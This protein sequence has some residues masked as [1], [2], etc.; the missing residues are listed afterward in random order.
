MAVRAWVRGRVGAIFAPS[1]GS[2][3]VHKFRAEPLRQ[4]LSY[5]ACHDVG[6]TTGRK[7]DNDAR[8]ISLRPRAARRGRERGSTPCQMQ[9]SPAGKFHRV[10]GPP[11]RRTAKTEPLPGSLATVTTPPIL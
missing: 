8:R 1:S 2:V 11:G 3:L 10:S 9:K 6:G 7:S 4:P 5:Q